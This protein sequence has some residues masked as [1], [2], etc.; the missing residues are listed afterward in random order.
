MRSHCSHSTIDDDDD[1]DEEEVE[2]I[3]IDDD[4]DDDDDKE[5]ELSSSSVS[6]PVTFHVP[7]KTRIMLHDPSSSTYL[8]SRRSRQWLSLRRT[9]S[10][11]NRNLVACSSSDE[12][13]TPSSEMTDSEEQH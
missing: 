1:D 10:V 5:V 2:E 13:L 11:L 9:V 8:V 6:T 7:S 3:E 12:A 4:D